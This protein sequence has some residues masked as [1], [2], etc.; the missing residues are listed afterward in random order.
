MIGGPRFS[1][2]SPLPVLGA[3]AVLGFVS[4]D[5]GNDGGG[6]L[7][8]PVCLYFLATLLPGLAVSVRR[9]HHRQERLVAAAVYGAW[10][11]PARR[12]DLQHRPD[13]HHVSGQRSGVNQYGP[14]PKFPEQTAG[15]LAGS[16]GFVSMGLD[17]Q[18]QPFMAASDL[19]V[20]GKCGAK[21]P[22]ASTFCGF[23]GAP[24]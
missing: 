2:S 11:D 10:H 22:G 4:V 1:L 18:P 19:A 14:N 8:A 20:C 15:A 13:R 21:L 3:V 17:G 5:K 12:I 7:I 23:C 6:V 24:V 16:A 9:L